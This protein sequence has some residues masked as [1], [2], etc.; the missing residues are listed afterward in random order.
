MNKTL[1]NSSRRKRMMIKVLYSLKILRDKMTNL[2]S[3][4]RMWK[5]MLK[6]SKR[7]S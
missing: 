1:I 6:K 7:K 4:M 5:K 2:K 3:K